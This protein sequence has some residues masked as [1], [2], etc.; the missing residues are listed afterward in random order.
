MP[1]SVPLLE[2]ES[3]WK[4]ANDPSITTITF[5][6]GS[7]TEAA[8][9]IKGRLKEVVAINP[10]LAGR[11]VRNKQHNRLQL[12]YPDKSVP[13]DGSIDYLFHVNPEGVKLHPEMPYHSLA[14][15]AASTIVPPV[16]SIQNKPFLVTRLTLVADSRDEAA[17][18]AMIFSM[19]HNVSDGHTYYKI[20]H[21]LSTMEKIEALDPV[22]M[23]DIPG[24]MIEAMGKREWGFFSSFTHAFNALRG[25]FFGRKAKVFSYYIDT[26]KVD[27]LKTEAAK[28]AQVSFVSTNDI[29]TSTFSSF[30]SPRLFMMTINFRNKLPG[31]DDGRA[32]NYSGVVFYDKSGYSNPS[33]VRNIL[34]GG[35]PYT[36][37]L[38]KFPG[39]VE[40]LFCRLGLITNTVAFTLDFSF[41]GCEEIL[42]FPL[43]DFTLLPYDIVYVFRPKHGKL[44]V[45]Y[46]TRRFEHAHF[47]SSNLP[48]GGAVSTEIF[49][50]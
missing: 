5:F 18:F 2:S 3:S 27:A 14:K 29:L 21:M 11:F 22:R 39:I 13:G 42:H 49:A 10:W 34:K 37:I 36:G 6:K 23:D 31:L 44:G 17:G 30:M 28:K 50:C 19:S 20:L 48:I 9:K 35:P 41:D 4:R 26:D 33:A 12:V 8:P 40:A 32:G 25:A 46:A 24:Q 1:V 16:R 7:L 15:A 43:F 38:E 45:L 47:V